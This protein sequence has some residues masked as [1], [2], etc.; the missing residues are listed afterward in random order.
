MFCMKPK[1]RSVPVG[2]WYCRRCVTNLGLVNSTDSKEKKKKLK[3]AFVIDDE[4]E[5]LQSDSSVCSQSKKI[6]SGNKNKKMTSTEIET[7]VCNGVEEEI[8]EYGED[9][10]TEKS[11]EEESLCDDTREDLSETFYVECNGVNDESKFADENNSEV[12]ESSEN[13]E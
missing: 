3:R 9:S 4:D 6:N 12:D 1:M 13:E 2:N 5:H 8:A 11:E 10:E 7:D